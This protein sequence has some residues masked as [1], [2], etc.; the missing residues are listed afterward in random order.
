MNIQ[1][2]QTLVRIFMSRFHTVKQDKMSE[3]FNIS[4]YSILQFK[5]CLV[6]GL[7]KFKLQG[8]GNCL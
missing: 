6:S 8:T 1:A 2:K 7:Q 5:V 3:Y 4:L